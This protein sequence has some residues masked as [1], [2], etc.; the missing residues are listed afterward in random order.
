MNFILKYFKKFGNNLSIYTNSETYSETSFSTPISNVSFD[1]LECCDFT[2][3][4][5]VIKDTEWQTIYSTKGILIPRKSTVLLYLSQFRLLRG[6]WWELFR[7]RSRCQRALLFL[8]MYR[9]WR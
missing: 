4:G 1:E 5:T 7:V 2:F 8:I 6:I 3:E 9:L